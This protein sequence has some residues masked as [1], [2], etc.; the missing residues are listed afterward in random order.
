MECTPC[1]VVRPGGGAPLELLEPDTSTF[2]GIVRWRT[3]LEE[4]VHYLRSMKECVPGVV[5]AVNAWVCCADLSLGLEE[6]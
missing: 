6:C 3:F 2:G 5:G 1:L 4:T